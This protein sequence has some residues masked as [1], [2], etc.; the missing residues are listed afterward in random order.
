[1]NVKHSVGLITA[2]LSLKHIA[3][4]MC[5]FVIVVGNAF[6]EWNVGEHD[7][8]LFG[9]LFMTLIPASFLS[10]LRTQSELR[11]FIYIF[12]Q[13][14]QWLIPLIN[15]IQLMKWDCGEIS[16]CFYADSSSRKG[17]KQK[18]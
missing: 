15:L 8:S 7:K 18:N 2:I 10:S 6:V 11:R 16:L 13:L 4:L 14:T 17:I 3:E 1:M 5:L 12:S 9:E